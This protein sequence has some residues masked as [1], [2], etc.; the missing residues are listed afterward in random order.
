V[1]AAGE[2][3]DGRA[4]QPGDFASAF[5][6]AFA[7]LQVLLEIA[8]VGGGSWPER[9]SVAVRQALEFAVVDPAAA[10]VLTNAALGQGRDG[11]ERYERLMAYLAGL[12]EAGRAESPH[13]ADLPQTTERSLAGG[14]ATIVANR[15]DRGRAEELPGLTAEVVQFVLTPYMGT[16]EARRIATGGDWPA[17]Q[18]DR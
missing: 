9:A 3:M 6:S 17:S 1:R 12:L 16:E 2:G 8:C 14:V 4:E 10:S 15:V 5:E 11:L 18:P 7:R 13:G